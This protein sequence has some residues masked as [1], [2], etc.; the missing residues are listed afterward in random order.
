MSWGRRF[1]LSTANT[2]IN[3]S[4]VSAQVAEDIMQISAGT[5]KSCG[6]LLGERLPQEGHRRALVFNHKGMSTLPL[7]N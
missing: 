7:H 5:Q 4:E 3:Q 1:T 6:V 2:D